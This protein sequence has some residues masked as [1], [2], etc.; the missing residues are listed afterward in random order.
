VERKED[1]CVPTRLTFREKDWGKS[2]RGCSPHTLGKH[3]GKVSDISKL[4]ISPT[5]FPI[6]I[7]TEDGCAGRSEMKKEGRD[8]K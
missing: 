7:R 4:N 5:Q 3:G 2:I 8:K 1:E 6:I